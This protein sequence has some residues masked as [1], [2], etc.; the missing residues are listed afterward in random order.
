MLSEFDE[1]AYTS[2]PKYPTTGELKGFA[3][4]E[5]VTED[6]AKRC[7]LK[8]GTTEFNQLHPF[9]KQGSHYMQ[10]LQRTAGIEDQAGTKEYYD[11][12]CKQHEKG[13]ITKAATSASKR[14][15]YYP[16]QCVYLEPSAMHF[17]DS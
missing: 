16:I 2:L 10:K 11:L 7:L 6:G 12:K 5:F 9:P 15:I 4:V 8:Y 13:P 14:L 3:F 1:I 17:S